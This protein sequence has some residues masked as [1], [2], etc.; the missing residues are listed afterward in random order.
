MNFGTLA[1]TCTERNI[2]QTVPGQ[3]CTKWAPE[4]SKKNGYK[5]KKGVELSA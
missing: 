1:N 3:S 2:N 5:N 4:L